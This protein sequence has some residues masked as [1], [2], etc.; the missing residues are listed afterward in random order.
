MQ[1]P[2]GAGREPTNVSGAR[3]ESTPVNKLASVA[4]TTCMWLKSSYSRN[5]N[6]IMVKRAKIAALG[7]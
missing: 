5:Y 1:R 4:A 2:C 3:R 7:F 6:A